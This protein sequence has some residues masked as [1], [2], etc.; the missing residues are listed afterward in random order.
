MLLE[1]GQFSLLLALAR[2]IGKPRFGLVMSRP[3]LAENCGK[4]ATMQAEA[5][6]DPTGNSDAGFASWHAE[7]AAIN[8]DSAGAIIQLEGTLA[9]DGKRIDH[10]TNDRDFFSV[11]TAGVAVHRLDR[12]ARGAGGQQQ[13]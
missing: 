3:G 5:L 7:I 6:L 1:N 9:H 10:P 13:R 2:F 12:L 11:K 4:V 8:P